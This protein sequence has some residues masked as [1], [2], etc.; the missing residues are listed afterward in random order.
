MALHSFIVRIAYHFYSIF[1]QIFVF[2][3]C[4]NKYISKAFSLYHHFDIKSSLNCF[5]II[6]Y[7]IFIIVCIFLYSFYNLLLL[8]LYFDS[9]YSKE[10]LFLTNYFS[11]LIKIFFSSKKLPSLMA[12]SNMLK[13][14]ILF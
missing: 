12:T 7:K 6:F 1:F 3:C 9:L 2:L 5:H 8:K 14:N 4:D 11:V 10:V 13:L